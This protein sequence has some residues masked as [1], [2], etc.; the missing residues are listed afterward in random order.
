MLMLTTVNAAANVP[1]ATTALT[2]RTLRAQLI[3]VATAVR[4]VSKATGLHANATWASLGRRALLLF[5]IRV[6]LF[7][8]VSS[9]SVART[10]SV[11]LSAMTTTT[12]SAMVVTLVTTVNLLHVTILAA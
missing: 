10:A 2:A 4:V 7:C 8:V 9:T 11:K 5:A 1:P 12:V 6:A 3:H